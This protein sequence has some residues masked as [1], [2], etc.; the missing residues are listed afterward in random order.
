MQSHA[1]ARNALDA[2]V[3]RGDVTLAALDELA[4]GQIAVHH[5]AIHR[6]VGRVDLQDQPGL[7]HRLVLLAHLARDRIEIG[8]VR[9][10]VRVEHGGRDDAGRGCGHEPL[11]ERAELAG[12]LVEAGGLFGDRLEIAILDVGLRLGRGVLALGLLREAAHQISEQLRE[13]LEL[14]AAPALG[15]AGEARHALR[16][17]GLETDALLFAIVADVDAG[18]HLLR[19]HVTDGLV[20]LGGENLR[21]VGLAFLLRH[22]QVGEFFVPRQ[23][24][25]VGGEDA[26]AAE[27]H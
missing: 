23:A 4:V 5:G 2:F 7:V 24:A 18:G 19:N 25:N 11:G 1:V 3:D 6:E 12:E 8:V 14:A 17:V 9:I 20:H 22:Q 15:Y 13:L 21:V 16:H 26:I 27:D 10:V